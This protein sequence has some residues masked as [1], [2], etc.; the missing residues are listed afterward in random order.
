MKRVYLCV[1]LCVCACVGPVCLAG[2]DVASPSPHH[3]SLAFYLPS[4]RPSVDS[5]LPVSLRNVDSIELGLPV[6]KEKKRGRKGR[7][8]G[9]LV[10]IDQ[11]RS[12]FSI[13][14]TMFILTTTIFSSSLLLRFCE[15]DWKF[16][17]KRMEEKWKI[18]KL[19]Q[20]AR[21]KTA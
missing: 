16:S 18:P 7:E 2:Q 6:R 5:F 8:K 4:V 13:K 3:I 19:R 17:L 14:H 1:C 21:Y 9:V 20:T 12:K 11:W 10:L 15:W